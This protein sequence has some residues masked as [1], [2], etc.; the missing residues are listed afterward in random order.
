MPTI[1]LVDDNADNLDIYQTVLE[2]AGYTVLLA[3]N[4]QTAVHAVREHQPDLVVMDVAMPVMDGLE[5]TRVLKTDP[6]TTGIHIVALTAHAMK[7]DQAR[8]AEAGC[9]G[10]LAK[11]LEPKALLEEVRKILEH[12]GSTD[13]LGRT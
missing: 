6:A 13:T 9:D 1:L 2:H 8:V 12:G 7:E 5:A 4:G 10:Y 11:P 3:H